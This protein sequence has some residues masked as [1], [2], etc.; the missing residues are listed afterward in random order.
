MRKTT[1]SGEV[2]RL[3]A[4]YANLPPKQKQLAQG[5]IVQ[6]AR[7]RV[8]LDELNAD[9]QENGKTEMF[10]QSDKVDPYERQRP[11]YSMFIKTDKNYLAIISKLNEMLPPEEDN[12]EDDE[13]SQ[14]RSGM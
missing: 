9:I 12:S 4:I 8:Q 6:A 3:S 2:K 14:F 5:L 10:A 1:E 7:L 13:I 11:S